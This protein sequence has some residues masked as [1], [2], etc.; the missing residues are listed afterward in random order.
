MNQP[1]RFIHASDFHLERPPRGLAEVPDHSAR[2]VRRRT[3]SRRR[4]GV[5]RGDSR[6]ASTSS[7]WPATWSTRAGRPARNRVLER[8]VS[9]PGRAGHSRLLG[10]RT[11]A[12]TSSAGPTPGRWPTTSCDSPAIASSASCIAA[13]ANRCCKSWAPAPSNAKESALADFRT[14]GRRPVR[15]GRGVRP[16]RSRGACKTF[17]QL[18]GTGGRTSAAGVAFRTY[19]RPLSGHSAGPPAARVGPARLHAGAG[20]RIAPGPHQFIPTDA[21]RYL[22]DRVAANESTTPDQLAQILGERIAELAGDPFGPDLLIQWIV[23]G[24]KNLAGQLRR[25]KLAVDLAGAAAGRTW[26]APPRRVDRLD[27]C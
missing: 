3:V 15:R 27:R 4:A 2:R 9:P 12:T 13:T 5:R 25:G 14:D 26:H 16:G 22:E 8:T 17:G 21:V 23:V 19:R 10:R 11:A 1:F 18:L 6:S 7:S 24:S 20:R